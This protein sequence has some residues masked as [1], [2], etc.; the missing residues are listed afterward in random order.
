MIKIK[1]FH[2]KR[3]NMLE[4]SRYNYVQYSKE[5]YPPPPNARFFNLGKKQRLPPCRCFSNF[6]AVFLY[7]DIHLIHPI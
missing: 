5:D 6:K 1:K 2:K 7:K 4:L 3:K